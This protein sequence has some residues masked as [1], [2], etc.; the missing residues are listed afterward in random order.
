MPDESDQI[1]ARD[2][3]NASL[4]LM[5]ILIAVITFLA[6]E[7]KGV[8]RYSYAPMAAPIRD[9]VWGTTGASVWAGIIAFGAL[10]KLRS[11]R[12]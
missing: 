1:F 6:V 8:R 3:F 10:I 5:S 2:V 11:G 4:T 9:A 12:G 7:Y